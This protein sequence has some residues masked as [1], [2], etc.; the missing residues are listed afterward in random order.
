VQDSENK[1]IFIDSLTYTSQRTDISY[2]R[3]I[4]GSENWYAFD[5]PTPLH[6]N[7]ITDIQHNEYM[8]EDITLY[9][10]YPN[11]FSSETVI[12][13]QFPAISNIELSVYE[14]EWNAEG[15]TPGIYFCEL[16]AGQNRKI[17]KMILLK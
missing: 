3:Y 10:N 11:P 14:V 15:M 12:G 2:G 1:A 17:I 4:N 16:K 5:N 9:Q 13:Y 7:I 6:S 8:P